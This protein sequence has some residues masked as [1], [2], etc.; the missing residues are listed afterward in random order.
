MILINSL[1][2]GLHALFTLFF[3]LYF[4]THLLFNLLGITNPWLF[5]PLSLILFLKLLPTFHDLYEDLDISPFSAI[6]L[7]L[8]VLIL[9]LINFKI[10][11]DDST[12]THLYHLNTAFPILLYHDLLTPQFYDLIGYS[13]GYP[14]F[15][16]FIQANFIQLTHHFAGYGLASI[17]VIPA[18]YT[19]TYLLA[20]TLGF[21]RRLADP[22]ALIYAFNPIH[23][24]Q[25]TTGYLDSLQSLYILITLLLALK[26]TT[27]NR[28]PLFLLSTIALLNIK[29]T[30]GLLSLSLLLLHLIWNGVHFRHHKQHYLLLTGAF[31]TLGSSHYLNNLLHFGTLI[32]P[33]IDL[34]LAYF[35][36]NQYVGTDTLLTQLAKL[37]WSPPSSLPTLSLYDVR[38]GAFSYLWYPFPFLILITLFKASIQRAYLILT[39]QAILLLFLLLDPGLPWGRYVTYYQVAGF[40]ALIF[41]F[42]KPW[43]AYLFSTA[44]L[45]LALY[46]LTNPELGLIKRRIDFYQAN[47]ILLDSIKS[48]RRLSFNYYY[49]FNSYCSGFYWLLRH[50]Q[51]PVHPI[52]DPSLLHGQTNYFYLHRNAQNQCHF[53]LQHNLQTSIQAH[54][55]P[56]QTYIDITVT[57]TSALNYC[58]QCVSDYGCWYVPYY[59]GKHT[60]DPSQQFQFETPGLKELKWRCQTIEGKI[61]EK[62][63]PFQATPHQP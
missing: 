4:L 19:T 16:E 55:L 60:L 15:G 46:S 35:T 20:K 61:L 6:V 10:G 27:L 32:Y 21:D 47:H 5:L 26:T 18:S 53:T 51:L 59:V 58:Q 38:Q 24:A 29:F 8:A 33:F 37:F 41:L 57:N 11:L 23:I 49:D 43:L 34:K 36:L 7:T 39:V 42:P 40:I 45:G 44:Y 3:P 1:L 31:W 28:L 2:K 14:K 56:P 25:A 30:G 9:I 62:S 63:I 12:D 54:T 17:L 52:T 48:T 13:Q 50:H 22:V